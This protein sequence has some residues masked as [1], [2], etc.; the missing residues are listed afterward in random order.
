[1]V[2]FID[3]VNEEAENIGQ[4]VDN[5][6]K[7]QFGIWI[8]KGGNFNGF[9]EYRI[10]F[11]TETSE[12]AGYLKFVPGLHGKQDYVLSAL[13]TDEKYRG[14]NLSNALLETLFQYA[15]YNGSQFTS[16]VRQ[17]KPLT[18][19]ILQKYGFMPV[20]NRPRDTVE[21]MGRYKKTD[22]LIAFRDKTKRTEF[23]K[24]NLC[25]NSMQYKVVDPNP[26]LIESTITL[27]TPYLLLQPDTCNNRR[28]STQRRFGINFYS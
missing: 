9:P 1:M 7:E 19:F 5:I 12:K 8:K 11:K 4:V 10:D 3:D 21:I 26:T 25:S 18:A 28:R 24:S 16:T 14:Q 13:Q 23:E 15:E 20:D 2:M 27:L 17:R 6:T 22:L